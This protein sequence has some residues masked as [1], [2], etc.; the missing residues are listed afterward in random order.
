MEQCTNL[1]LLAF[2]D[3]KHEKKQ[4]S[5]V[6]IDEAHLMIVWGDF[7]P[8]FLYLPSFR[9]YHAVQWVVLSATVPF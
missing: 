8:A 9:R 7:R 6:V 4:L 5:R 2:L 3:K 1:D